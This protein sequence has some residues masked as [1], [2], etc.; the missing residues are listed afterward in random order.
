M[1]STRC[2]L[3]LNFSLRKQRGCQSLPS[4]SASSRQPS[5]RIARTSSGTGRCAVSCFVRAQ[6]LGRHLGA[7]EASYA[8][9][10]WAPDPRRSSGDRPQDH[11]GV[12]PDRAAQHCR[13]SRP[14]NHPCRVLARPLPTLGAQRA[15]KGGQV[16]QSPGAGLPG[17]G[18]HAHVRRQS[19]LV[20]LLVDGSRVLNYS[21]RG[22]AFSST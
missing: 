19:R 6:S 21:A 14:E 18:R 7:R 16:H 5:P 17:R 12:H 8:E 3:Q 4:P 9:I 22:S 11:R 13:A 15:Q 2:S 20:R 10:C 1:P